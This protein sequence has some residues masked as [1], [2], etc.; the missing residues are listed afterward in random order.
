MS[1]LQNII[2][3]ENSLIELFSLDDKRKMSDGKFQNFIIFLNWKKSYSFDYIFWESRLI[4]QQLINKIR[5]HKYTTYTSTENTKFTMMWR[6]IQPADSVLGVIALLFT[7]QN[8]PM[9]MTWLYYIN[10]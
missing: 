5:S 4:K 1:H 10:L 2:T 8:L 3:S 7:L 6:T 9:F